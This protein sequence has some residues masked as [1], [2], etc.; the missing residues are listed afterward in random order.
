MSKTIEVFT[1]PNKRQGETNEVKL[2]VTG[3]MKKVPARKYVNID[4]AEVPINPTIGSIFLEIKLGR[5]YHFVY[6]NAYDLTFGISHKN[7][8]TYKCYM[9]HHKTDGENSITLNNR[10]SRKKDEKLLR[11]LDLF[12]EYIK[13]N[14]IK[15]V[16]EKKASPEGYWAAF[17]VTPINCK[18]F[19]DFG[20]IV[21]SDNFDGALERKKMRMKKSPSNDLKAYDSVKEE[22]IK[23]YLR[24]KDESRF[25]PKGNIIKC[26]SANATEAWPEDWT[27]WTIKNASAIIKDIEIKI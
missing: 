5:S 23:C 4:I 20:N 15:D 9:N 19:V 26:M 2:Q 6:Q 16:S 1:Y 11:V 8:N 10:T 18:S 17:E 3:G 12:Y 7:H 24:F 22:C 21:F 14:D 13:I 25:T 27:D